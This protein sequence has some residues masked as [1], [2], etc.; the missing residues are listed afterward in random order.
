MHD[1]FTQ[2]AA[3]PPS[4][5]ASSTLT[6]KVSYWTDTAGLQSNDC[7]PTANSVRKAIV[8]P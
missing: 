6:V 3:V 5:P 7:P 4:E 8:L 2:P 1:G